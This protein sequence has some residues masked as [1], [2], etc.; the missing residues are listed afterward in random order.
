VVCALARRHPPRALI[1]EST[2][3]SVTDVARGMGV[4]S[5]FIHDRFES[6]PVVRTFEGPVLVLH[7]THDRLVPVANGRALAAANPRA[8]LALYPC[9]HNDLPPPGSDYW[10]R[11]DALLRDA[12]VP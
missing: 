8:T 7:G 5:L 10:P 6:L 1:L 12:G 9:G 2:F 11:I 3:T 4:P